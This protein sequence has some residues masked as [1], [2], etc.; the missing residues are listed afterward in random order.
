MLAAGDLKFELDGVKLRGSWAL[1]KMRGRQANAWLLIKHNDAQADRE[2]DVTRQN[3][4]VVS[5][6][7]LPRD[8]GLPSTAQRRAARRQ[9]R[10]PG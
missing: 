8:R 10:S 1:V 6:R 5:G 4:S 2:R 3:E 9:R 7:L